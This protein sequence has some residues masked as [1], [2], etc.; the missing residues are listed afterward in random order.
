MSI[1]WKCAYF[2]WLALVSVLALIPR[3]PLPEEGLL[4]W[5]KLQHLGAFGVMTFLGACAFTFRR[6]ANVDRFLLS[7][8]IAAIIG[9]LIEIAQ[10]VFT[11]ARNAD[12]E[13]FI[14]DV[15]G[16]GLVTMAAW[17]VQEWRAAR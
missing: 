14:A 1:L 2:F 15:I 4:A 7:A 12:V 3:P 13:D 8:L 16:A 9:G 10:G 6:Y 17:I 5:D 11:D